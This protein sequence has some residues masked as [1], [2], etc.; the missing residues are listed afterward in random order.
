V[1]VL[2]HVRGASVSV[3]PNLPN[4]LNRFALSSK[5]FAYVALGIP[6]ACADLPT[7]RE[8]FSVREILSSPPPTR[9]PSR[10][11]PAI[12]RDPGSAAAR[13]RAALARY[14]EEY[15]LVVNA[16]RYASILDELTGITIPP[17][18]EGAQG[19]SRSARASERPRPPSQ[20]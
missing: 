10:S 17:S 19:I 8:R 4:R 11:S 1:E 3:I 7:L 14:E 13:A 20:R 6:V 2:E 16:G 5:L 9:R 18:L 15:S 12:R